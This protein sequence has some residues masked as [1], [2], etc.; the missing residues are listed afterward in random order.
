MT[1]DRA[2]YAIK[3]YAKN[4]AIEVLDTPIEVFLN[5]PNMGGNEL[6]WTTHVYLPIKQ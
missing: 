3:N 1:S 2:W 5:N 4:N 6:D